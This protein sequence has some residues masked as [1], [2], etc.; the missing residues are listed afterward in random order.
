M[1]LNRLHLIKKV[2]II[3]NNYVNFFSKGKKK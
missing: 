1:Q 2:K 3:K